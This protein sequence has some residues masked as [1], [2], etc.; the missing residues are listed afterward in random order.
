MIDDDTSSAEE[1]LLGT[2]FQEKSTKYGTYLYKTLLTTHIVTFLVGI[3][4][5]LV[6][7]YGFHAKIPSARASCQTIHDTEFSKAI[8]VLVPFRMRC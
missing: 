3:T 4:L 2:T 7:G 1:A 5:G 8:L 6:L